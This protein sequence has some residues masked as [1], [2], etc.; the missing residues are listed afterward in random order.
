MNWTLYDLPAEIRAE[1]EGPDA[2]DDPAE[3]E[4]SQDFSTLTDYPYC[5]SRTPESCGYSD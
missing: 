2:P 1:E 4:V 5:G 3:L